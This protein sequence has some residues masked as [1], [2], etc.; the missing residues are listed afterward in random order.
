MPRARAGIDYCMHCT[1][2]PRHPC[3]TNEEVAEC[4]NASSTSR[5]FARSN[6]PG[7]SQDEAAEL[8]EYRRRYGPLR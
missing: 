6:L 4:P 5:E 8:A 2:C 7:Y 3:R 1:A